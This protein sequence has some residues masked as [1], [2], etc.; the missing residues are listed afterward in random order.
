[1]NTFTQKTI[2][3]RKKENNV[4][5]WVITIAVGAAVTAAVTAMVNKRMSAGSSKETTPQQEIPSNQ[6]KAGQGKG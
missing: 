6:V 3:A 2:V 4:I 1:V 5:T